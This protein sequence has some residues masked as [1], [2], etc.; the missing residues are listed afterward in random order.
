MNPILAGDIGGTRARFALL[1]ATG[2]KVLY[3][4]VLESRT[5][6]TF[7]AALDRFL[8]G[9]RSKGKSEPKRTIR[10]ASF[11]IA[12][13]IVDQRVKTTNLPWV[14]DAATIAAEFRIE[15]VTLLND[16]VAV[17]LGAIAA[18]PS[19]LRSIH[20][21]KPKKTGGNLAVIAA[22]TGL[23]EAAFVWDGTTHVACPTEGAHV[24]FAPRTPVEIELWQLLAR[25]H[26][27]VSYERVASGST[28]SVLYTFFVRDVRVPESASAASLVAKAEDPNVAVVDL[29]LKGKSEAAM[30][31]VELWCSVYG[32]EAGNLALKSFATAGLYICGGASARL[33]DVLAGGLPT[34]RKRS[35]PFIEA[36]VDK[37]R[38]RPL[39]E[40]IPIAVCTEPLAGLFGAA[41][42][43]AKQAAARNSSK[44]PKSRARR[45]S[46]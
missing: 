9:A 4:D 42:H 38:M 41:A 30:R 40:K 28:I 21:G 25:E 7:E 2:R 24:D 20:A 45:K 8:E 34:R 37:G 36:F 39:L 11:G 18:G 13:P 29:A 6:P 23:G 22:G 43:A 46:G 1:E 17:G 35:S 19:M 27:H 14:I 32:A 10:A 3:Q 15:R 16:L 5:F 33:A 12:G 44:R 31:A 26:G